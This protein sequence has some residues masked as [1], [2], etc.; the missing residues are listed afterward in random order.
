MKSHSPTT[1]NNENSNAI[2]KIR[3]IENWCPTTCVGITQHNRL[4]ETGRRS[5]PYAHCVPCVLFTSIT[6]HHSRRKCYH[7]FSFYFITQTLQC[8][9]ALTSSE[10]PAFT[11]NKLTGEQTGTAY[12]CHC[13]A[14]LVYSTVLDRKGHRGILK[15]RTMNG[16]FA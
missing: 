10:R 13:S 12:S 8:M 4:A 1:Q 6:W 15:A 5:R 3:I 7:R 11:V 16:H 9:S 14:V 2:R